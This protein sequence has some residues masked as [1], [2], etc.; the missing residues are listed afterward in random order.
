MDKRKQKKSN[1]HKKKISEGVKK[2][3][4]E[5]RG[6][7]SGLLT[8]E[9]RKK[10][11][12]AMLGHKRTPQGKKHFAWK[13]KNAGYGAKHDWVERVLGKPKKCTKCGT[14]KAKKFE[15]ANKSGKYQ[16]KI[17]DWIRLCSKCHHKMDKIAERG[18]ATKKGFQLA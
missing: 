17:K 8:R 6:N 13:G 7:F 9:S 4:A 10:N 2:Q 1:E 5:G 3:W 14:T 15:W 11:R 12:L 16:R 18:W